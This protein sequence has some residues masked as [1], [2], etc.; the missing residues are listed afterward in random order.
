MNV[1]LRWK[2]CYYY[3]FRT[4]SSCRVSSGVGGGGSSEGR[5]GSCN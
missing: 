3:M 2:S 4:F 1:K 5:S